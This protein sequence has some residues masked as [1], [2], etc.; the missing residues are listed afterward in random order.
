MRQVC[1]KISSEDYEKL[2]SIAEK[3]GKTLYQVLRE[4]VYEYIARHGGNPR[5]ASIEA[6]LRGIIGRITELEARLIKLE[7]ELREIKGKAQRQRG[8]VTK[9]M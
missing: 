5:K 8:G 7:R 1:T 2:R 6:Q 3:E 4:L 9:W